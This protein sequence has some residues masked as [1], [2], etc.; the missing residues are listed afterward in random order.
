M[1]N[2]AVESANPFS[3]TQSTANPMS[4]GKSIGN[5]STRAVYRIGETGG[6]EEVA[7]EQLERHT[8]RR[9]R[10]AT[11]WDDKVQVPL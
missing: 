10:A 9:Q 7:S 1:C 5:E 3:G 2:D 6:M 11:R 8:G 4:D